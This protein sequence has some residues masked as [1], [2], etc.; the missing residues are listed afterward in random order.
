MENGEQPMETLPVDVLCG[1]ADCLK[2]MAHPVRLQIVDILMQEDLSVRELAARC[3]VQEHQICGH[4]R[5]MQ[6]CG[7][8]EGERRG[9]AVHYRITSPNLP[10]LIQCIRAHFL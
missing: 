6:R 10:A 1:A 9:R 5:L 7:L 8:L 2:I 4:L 3:G